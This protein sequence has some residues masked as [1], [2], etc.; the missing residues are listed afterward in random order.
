MGQPLIGALVGHTQPATM[1]GYRN[2]TSDNKPARMVVAF[3]GCDIRFSI[4]CQ[5]NLLRDL[6]LGGVFLQFVYISF[7]RLD[8]RFARFSKLSGP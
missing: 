6:F 8:L 4:P 1:V 7:L 3:A 5:M 2:L